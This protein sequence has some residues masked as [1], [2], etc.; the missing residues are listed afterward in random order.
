MR[1]RLAAAFRISWR[2]LSNSSWLAELGNLCPARF[3]RNLAREERTTSPDG[4]SG[5]SHAGV[6]SLIAVGGTGLVYGVGEIS[7][8]E[9]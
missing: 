7:N 9:Y 4:A 6:G 1:W 5:E 2:T 8:I 3:R